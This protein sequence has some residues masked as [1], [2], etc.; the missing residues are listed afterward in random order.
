MAEAF[1]EEFTT[2]NL[3]HYPK[4]LPRN[5]STAYFQDISAWA[6]DSAGVKHV[7]MKLGGMAGRSV[8]LWWEFTQ[9]TAL[10]CKDVRLAAPSAASWLI[11][12]FSRASSRHRRM[13]Q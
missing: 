3:N 5:N 4:H 9:D 12:S 10:T 1:E 7:H 13:F 11:T 8:R 2:D 6:G